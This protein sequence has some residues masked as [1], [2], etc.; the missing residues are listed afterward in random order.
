[1]EIVVF[2]HERAV[3]EQVPRGCLDAPAAQ[4]VAEL[5]LGDHEQPP[6]RG[7]AR[8]V[9]LP[10]GGDDGGEG[11]GSEIE[12]DLT[13]PYTPQVKPGDGGQPAQIEDLERLLL[14][15]RGGEQQ[16]SV[17]GIAIAHTR[18]YASR[19]IL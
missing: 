3:P 14:P 12:R 18:S 15:T 10:A 8:G 7:A 16:R 2:E 6:G 17:V 1:M 19:A 13:H 4:A 11:L 9:K 5:A